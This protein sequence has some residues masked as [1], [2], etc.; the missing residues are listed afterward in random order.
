M[1]SAIVHN[2]AS[3]ATCVEVVSAFLERV[4]KT[5]PNLHSFRQINAEVL[6]REA[7][8]LDAL[9]ADQRGPLHGELVAIKEVLD[10]AGYTCG[11][12][13]YTHLTLPTNREV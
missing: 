9:P 8:A 2:A 13:S 1:T 6:Y 11:S 12:V 3:D 7:A 4:A 5:E 10:V